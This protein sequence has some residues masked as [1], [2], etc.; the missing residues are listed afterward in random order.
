MGCMV[1]S[2]MGDEKLAEGRCPESGDKKE[3]RK[4][5]TTMGDC[6]IS[7]LERIG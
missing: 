3:V 7:D 5:K 6:I 4:I 2:K 1:M